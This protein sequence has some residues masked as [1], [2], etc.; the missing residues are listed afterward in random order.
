MPPYIVALKGWDIELPAPS[1]PEISY[2]SDGRYDLFIRRWGREGH[3]HGQKVLML[4]KNKKQ[5]GDTPI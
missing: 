3:R 5:P 4:A 2:L 1:S